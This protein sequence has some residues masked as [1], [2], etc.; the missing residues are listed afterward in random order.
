MILQSFFHPIVGVRGLFYIGSK[1]KPSMDT[2]C[3]SDKRSTG[4]CWDVF[5]FVKN[6][7]RP[8][9]PSVP[10]RIRISKVSVLW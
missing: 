1:E 7:R 2:G 4:R 9:W 6:S 5:V 3:L 8:I 10:Q